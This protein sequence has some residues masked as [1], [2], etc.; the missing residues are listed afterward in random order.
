MLAA[1]LVMLW[2]VPFDSTEARVDFPLDLKIDRFLLTAMMI[3]WLASLF[4]GGR[5]GPRFPKSMIEWAVLLFAGIAVA[6]VLVNIGTIV[7]LGQTDLATKKIAL[8]LSY[9]VFFFIVAT[10]LRTREVER[11]ANLF[12]ALACIAAVGV[13]YQYFAGRNLFFEW[14]AQIVPQDIF[15]IVGI[16]DT[17]NRFVDPPVTGPTRHALALATMFAMALSF[18]LVALA[19]SKTALRQTVYAVAVVL[20]LGGVFATSRKTGSFASIAALL[21]LFALRPRELGK[22]VPLGIVVFTGLLLTTPA[23]VEKQLD[24]VKPGE[25]AAG[26]SGV[27][28]TADYDAIVPDVRERVVLG[29][30]Y[31]TYDPH[32]FRILDN[33]YLVLLLET[34]LLGVGAFGFILFATLARSRRALRQGDPSGWNA[35]LAAAGATAALG[36]AMALFDALSYPQAPY[37]F[38]FLAGIVAVAG[39][40]RR[41]ALPPLAPAVERP[42]EREAL[43]PLREPVEREALPELREGLERERAAQRER[44]EVGEHGGRPRAPR[45]GRFGRPLPVR[46]HVSEPLPGAPPPEEEPAVPVRRRS[47][48]IRAAGERI[49]RRAGAIAVGL[50]ALAVG[51]FALGG[52]EQAGENGVPRLGKAGG[53]DGD[54]PFGLGQF[55]E[56]GAGGETTR[57][58]ERAG[59]E[60]AEQRPPEREAVSVVDVES[61]PAP[62]APR[63]RTRDRD[64]SERRDDRQERPRKRRRKRRR[65]PPPQGAPSPGGG[66][67]PAPPPPE[68]CLPGDETETFLAGIGIDACA[69]TP[70]TGTSLRLAYESGRLS[71][72]ELDYLVEMLRQAQAAHRG[73]NL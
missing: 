18:G 42:E 45:R 15:R 1:F 2:L 41:I 66:E 38:F 20:M 54:D 44:R 39:V 33:N 48:S 69:L 35:A 3:A 46:R 32:R 61:P 5:P 29:R 68:N 12:L 47:E 26:A 8:L 53:A 51:A 23:A 67:Q 28:R 25:I 65:P 43:P 24:Q 59:G 63:E 56:G 9:V 40:P 7:N 27:G 55:E 60:L 58:R 22:L 57:P 71:R 52:G 73:V 50:L 11:F 10:T 30:G 70:T 4:A 14:W 13:L 19:Q 17:G 34:G 16:V 72:A 36:V 21:T 49:R 62:G 37:M 64:R 31:G 6:S